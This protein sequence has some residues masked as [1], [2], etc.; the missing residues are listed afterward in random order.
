VHRVAKHRHWLSDIRG[1]VEQDR[2]H[3]PPQHRSTL[4]VFLQHVDMI[5]TDVANAQATKELPAVSIRMLL[6]IYSYWT[7]HNFLPKDALA[8][9]KVTLLDNA[10]TW[11]ADGAWSDT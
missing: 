9:N 8:D 4:V 7:E 6:S 2:T 11:L 5:I 3:F 10:D 1:Y